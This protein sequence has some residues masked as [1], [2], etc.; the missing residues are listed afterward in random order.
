MIPQNLV[1]HTVLNR[2]QLFTYVTI[3]ERNHC[4]PTRQKREQKKFGEYFV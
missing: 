3:S 4:S 1:S 2:S